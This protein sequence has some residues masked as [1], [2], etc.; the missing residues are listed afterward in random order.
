VQVNSLLAQPHQRSSAPLAPPPRNCGSA[1]D[2]ARGVLADIS[3]TARSI[4]AQMERDG[5]AA[6]S[7]DLHLD[8]RQ[9]GITV[10][11][12]GSRSVEGH[13]LTVDLHVEAIQGSFKTDDGEIAF[14]KLDVSFTM[15]ETYFQA[16][17]SAGQPQ[18]KG[19]LV[20]GLKKLVSLLD[21][22]NG[23][24]G[25]EDSLE[26]ILLQIGRALEAMAKRISETT[27]APE[28]AQLEGFER[29]ETI[30]LHALHFEA[31]AVQI[32]QTG[33]G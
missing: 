18:P 6:Q 24:P 17:G 15:E 30:E 1:P 5:V 29:R 26:D 31:S 22:T 10:G 28:A 11:A 8:L 19:G 20:D 27:A 7:F 12:N 3:E 9:L 14:Q 32:A 2:V 16:S 4:F 21:R 23:K 13:S 33:A 25:P